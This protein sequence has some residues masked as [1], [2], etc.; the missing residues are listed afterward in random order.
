MDQLDPVQVQTLAIAT[1]HLSAG[2]DRSLALI[3]QLGRSA[4]RVRAIQPE[5]GADIDHAG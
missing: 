5:P 1:S 4:A 3:C 2:S